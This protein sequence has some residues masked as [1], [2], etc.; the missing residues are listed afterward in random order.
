MAMKQAE[1]EQKLGQQAQTHE[2]KLNQ[3]AAIALQKMQVEAMKMGM[4]LD[5]AK[6][7]A[8]GELAKS[9]ASARIQTRIQKVCFRN[10]RSNSLPY[11]DLQKFAKIRLT[12]HLR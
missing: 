1:H 11:N 6:A 7:K 8:A 2:Q 12:G 5:A 9:E 10:R 3:D 4:Q